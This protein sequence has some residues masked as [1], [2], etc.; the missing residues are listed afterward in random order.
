MSLKLFSA[1]KL[2]ASKCNSS[3]VEK[4]ISQR[5]IKPSNALEYVIP[6]N[7]KL[8]A[9][10]LSLKAPASFV[11]W[12]AELCQIM[13]QSCREGSQLVCFPEY[14]GLMPLFTSRPLYEEA[15]QF[16][17][18]LLNDRDKE[19]EHSM[20]YFTSKLSHCL[21]D[22]YTSLFS[23]LASSYRIYVQAGSIL[24]KTR[25]G[26]VNHACLFGPDGKLILEQNKLHL[27]EHEKSIGII[28]GKDIQVVD[29]DLGKMSIL[30]G[31]DQRVFETAKAA[32]NQGAQ[33]L[34][35]PSGLSI[36]ESSSFFQSCAFMRCQEQE[37][38]AVCSWLTGDF[39]D[40]PFRA[41]SGIYSPFSISKSGNGII[42][43]SE[44][45]SGSACM[46]ARID[47][48]R[49]G[50]DVDLYKSD[51]NSAVQELLLSQ[52]S[53]PRPSPVSIDLYDEDG[54]NQPDEDE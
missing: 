43:Q 8:T 14:I 24:V 22:S 16:S 1:T 21:Y 18:D 53:S 17:D 49:L 48:E 51:I 37:M 39:M 41:I 35:C 26:F 3:R 23:S 34:L 54:E 6:S 9:I 2:F 42:V 10:Q 36:S 13:D 32:R 47:L 15:Y 40:L 31:K 33:I 28:P 44:N 29:S 11:D 12:M 38:F 50:K 7:I 20:T 27:S 45:P 52:Y 19:I 4:Y 5:H 46:T 25:D 30:I